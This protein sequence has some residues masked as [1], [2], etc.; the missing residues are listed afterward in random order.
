[1]MNNL[2]IIS[3]NNILKK[4]GIALVSASII[5]L[6]AIFAFEMSK[7]N[8]KAKQENNT[9]QI[10]K[11][12]NANDNNK[13][14]EDINKEIKNI[15]EKVGEIVNINNNDV[16]SNDSK[17]NKNTKQDKNDKKKEETFVET[18]KPVNYGYVE[19]KDYHNGYADLVER[20]IPAVVNVFA[21]RLDEEY[22]KELEMAIPDANDLFG[23][24]FGQNMAPKKQKTKAIGTAFFISSDGYLITNHHVV[25]K[26]KDITI[27]MH[28]GVEFKARLVG[29][30][31]KGDL[32]VL[33]VDEK[34]VKFPFVEFGDSDK[35]RLGDVVLAIG[36]PFGFKGSVTQGIVSGKTR[37]LDNSVDDF[38]QIDASINMGNSGGPTFTLDGKVIGINTM[39]VTP[40]SGSIGLGFAISSN[41]AQPIIKKLKSGKSIK[42][43][44]VG[45]QI[46][47]VTQDIANAIGL[48]KTHG[49]LVADVAQGSPAEK[50][51][52]KKGDVILSVNGT[53][54]KDFAMMQQMTGNL[55]I[56]KTATIIVNH[57]GKEKKLKIKVEDQ[58]HIEKLMNGE[59]EDKKELNTGSISVKALTNQLKMRYK[60]DRNVEGVLV[61][62][63]KDDAD[64]NFNIEVG[65]VIM[66]INDDE[67]KSIADFEKIIEKHKKQKRKDGKKENKSFVIHIY[68][69]GQP[70][71][72]GS[73]ID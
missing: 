71:V 73:N 19:P 16:N 31:E 45:I 34:G 26:A 59:K 68:R 50:G 43:G 65:D 4:I 28:N 15:G 56:G 1:M 58:E 30:D 17:Q 33:K 32:A 24:L 39:I 60:I 67:I 12:E 36:S 21:V 63:I 69:M 49:A 48:K 55:E 3:K 20:L 27:T 70:M 51:G 52:M 37:A 41:M 66:Q 6:I 57:Y 14:I 23:Y 10:E 61:S 7:S 54:I 25:E 44:M 22:D 53:E 64:I 29:Y 72:I 46:Q 38:I 2:W 9:Q 8:N 35:V 42:R 11:T 47:A 40:N 62:K 5:V 13:T 18:E